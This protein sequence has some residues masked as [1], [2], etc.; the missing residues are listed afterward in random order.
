MPDYHLRSATLADADALVRHRVGMFTDMGTP[1]D[2]AALADAFHSWLS[3]AMFS[4]VYRAWVVE[5]EAGEIVAGGGIS[6]LSWPPGPRDLRGRLPIV[7]NVYTEP[8]HR[9]RGL[10]RMIMEAIHAWCR[11]EGFKSV[12]L[13]ASEFGRPLYESMGY[14][15]SPQPYM[16]LGLE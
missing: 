13:A 7:Y 14:E 8:G 9:R 3:D 1:I 16:F 4:G 11:E 12:A 5:R 10:A 6:I 15:V 2:A